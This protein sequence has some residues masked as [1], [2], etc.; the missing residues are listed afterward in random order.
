MR[1][2]VQ[3]NFA[4]CYLIGVS[5]AELQVLR[6]ET[7]TGSSD[8]RLNSLARPAF[9]VSAADCSISLSTS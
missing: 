6:Q 4:L 5:M 9:H 7:Y 8:V 1:P 2:G 3:C